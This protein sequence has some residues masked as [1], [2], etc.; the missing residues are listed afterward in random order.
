MT[1]A[2]RGQIA[3]AYKAYLHLM[4]TRSTDKPRSDSDNRTLHDFTADRSMPNPEEALMPSDAVERLQVLAEQAGITGAE[5]GRLLHHFEREMSDP[6]AEQTS[7]ALILQ[8]LQHAAS[9]AD[10]A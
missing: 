8:K 4:G 7:L 1:N 6:G 2:K 10:S 9:V 5:L 3:A